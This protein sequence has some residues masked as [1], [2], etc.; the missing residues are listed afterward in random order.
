MKAIFNLNLDNHLKIEAYL[1]KKFL[2]ISFYFLAYFLLF[3]GYFNY[4]APSWN[5]YNFAWN[6]NIY[7]LF[8]SLVLIFI[9]V[10]FLP[11]TFKK[12]SDF[13]L[14]LQFLFP[15]LP[16]LVLFFAMDLSRSFMYFTC[17]SFLIIVAFSMF[18]C[19]KP[20]RIFKFDIKFLQIILLCFGYLVLMSIVFQ[21]GLK[22]F[23]LN[24]ARVYEFRAAAAANLPKVYGY[25]NPWTAK[26][27]F[28]FSLL[29]AVLTRKKI[30]VL[31]SL[32]GSILMFGLT[33]H[34][35]PLF[36]PFAV[37]FLY[38]ISRLKRVI[39][40]FVFCYISVIIISLLD[41]KTGIFSGW[42]AS[43]CLRRVIFVPA[44]LNFLYFDFFS[45]NRLLFWSE[46]KV[47]LG[48]FSK[49]FSLDTPHLIGYY[50]FGSEFIGANTGW[51]GSGYANAGF[52]GLL[53]YAIIIGLIFS[54]LNSLSKFHDK[55]IIVSI[56]TAPIFA[57]ML[58]SDL[59]T[60]IL[61]HG[62][63]IG[64]ILLMLFRTKR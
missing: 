39:I 3:I 31:F 36:Y 57:I 32:L 37:L 40:F 41:H 20:V 28:P 15:I 23:N 4:I 1:G 48:L 42:F 34:K 49:K 35:G 56:F 55:R 33:S 13:L 59:P 25:I 51:I 7:K 2:L 45:H 19:I 52:L 14:H 58:S 64:L 26:V 9:V 22:Y 24:L 16:M 63:L 43:L 46:S 62:T 44:L 17:L 12:P 29:L 60:A 30:L 27:I 50:Y 11:T 38:Y 6:P 47:T 18:F 53:I 10:V 54:F 5:Y 61:T 8:E 21:G